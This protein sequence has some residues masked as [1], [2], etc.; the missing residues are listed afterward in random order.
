MVGEHL[1]SLY[2]GLDSIHS[3]TNSNNKTKT[4]FFPEMELIVF[5]N[6]KHVPVF[7]APCV[8]D[9]VTV[10]K[11]GHTSED[12][13]GVRIFLHSRQLSLHQEKSGASA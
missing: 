2:Q 4:V 1:P 5:L 7:K 3:T 9:F 12:I 10:F 8:P 11:I 6:T 13:S